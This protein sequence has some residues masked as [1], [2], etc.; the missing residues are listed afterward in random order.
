MGFIEDIE[1]IWPRPHD[2]PDG[3]DKPCR[4][5]SASWP[6]SMFNPQV[7]SVG[8]RERTVA[9][10]EQRSYLVHPSDKLAALTRIFEMEDITSALIFTRTA[11][12]PASWLAS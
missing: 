4:L 7:V 8:P 3:A 2:P 1:A 9:A 10:I 5:R 6:T 11:P 12:A